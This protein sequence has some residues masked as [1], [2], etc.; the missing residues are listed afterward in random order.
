M[1]TL[2][3]PLRAAPRRRFW[4]SPRVVLCAPALIVLAL[5]F[6]MPLYENALRSVGISAI[7][8]AHS[9][10]TLSYYHKLFTDPY[11]VGIIFETLKM[12]IWTTFWCLIAG[13]PVAYF[14]VR[15]AG[16]MAGPLLFVLIMPLLT[17]IIMRTFGWSVLLGRHGLVN[18]ALMLLGAIEQPLRMTQGPAIVYV[19]NVHVMVSFM[20][21][22]II[23]VL[24]SVDPRLEESA[25]ALG[26]G[27]LRAFL[28]VTLPLSVDGIITGCLI[29][30][31]IINGSF[32]GALLLGGGSVVTLPLLIFQQFSQAQDMGFA[33]AMGNLLLIVVLICL[34]VQGRLTG[35]HAE[36]RA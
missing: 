32:I 23:P 11:Y 16:R 27:A 1:N 9:A 4:I 7:P 14:M 20:V 36:T 5:F 6:G 18:N 19:G 12:S 22:S 29:V 10:F 24:R 26:A 21:L 33:S 13:Y 28:L 8:G 3:N 35:H 17:S 34:Y 25:R 30:F 31:M 2:A 15:R